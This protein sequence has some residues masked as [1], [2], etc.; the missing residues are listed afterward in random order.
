M[1]RKCDMFSTSNDTDKHVLCIDGYIGLFDS[2]EEINELLAPLLKEHWDDSGYGCM[3]ILEP[4]DIALRVDYE[5]KLPSGGYGAKEST[6]CLVSEVQPIDI[7]GYV[8]KHADRQ[9]QKAKDE[10]PGL[11]SRFEHHLLSKLSSSDGDI[12]DA[13][14]KHGQ[15]CAERA[16]NAI[17]SSQ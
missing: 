13:V 7:K 4:G 14:F 8:E 1:K 17:K 2:A 11:K 16:E 10:R 6:T 5:N 9:W 3:Q 12:W 15:E